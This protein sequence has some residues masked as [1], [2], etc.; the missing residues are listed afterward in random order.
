MVDEDAIVRL[1]GEGRGR[2]RRERRLAP[3]TRKTA[4]EQVV[5]GATVLGLGVGAPLDVPPK[6]GRLPREEGELVGLWKQV[7]VC[8]YE[9]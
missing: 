3:G 5:G 1:V 2:G 6:I 4:G 8:V 9:A 7:L